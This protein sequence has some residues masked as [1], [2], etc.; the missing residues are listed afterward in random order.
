MRRKIMDMAG[1]F[2][3]TRVVGELDISLSDC[4]GESP[5]ACEGSKIKP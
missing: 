3:R 2:R 1:D 4:D 5:M